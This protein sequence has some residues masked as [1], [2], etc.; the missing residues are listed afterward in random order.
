MPKRSKKIRIFFIYLYVHCIH[1]YFIHYIF[2]V[3]RFKTIYTVL[4]QKIGEI[5]RRYKKKRF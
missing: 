3:N 2:K 4:G 5:L 1:F